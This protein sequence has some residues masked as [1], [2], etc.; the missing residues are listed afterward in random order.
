MEGP[1]LPPARFP[2]ERYD[3][4]TMSQFPGKE[5]VKLREWTFNL[6]NAVPAS[7]RRDNPT[8]P[9]SVEDVKTFGMVRTAKLIATESHDYMS[10]SDGYCFGI[11]MNFMQ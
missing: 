7:E 4:F 8:I 5:Y 6:R 2:E 9:Q 10:K 11:M 3:S 1:E